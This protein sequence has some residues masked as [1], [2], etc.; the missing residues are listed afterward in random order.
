MAI[1][2]SSGP[3]P[4]KYLFVDGGYLQN[5]LISLGKRMGLAESAPI[6]FEVLSSQYD[7]TI[8]FDAL[9]AKKPN[10]DQADFDKAF[11]AK[12][13]FLNN[14]RRIRNFHVRDGFTR[15]RPRANSGLEQKG[16]DT[17]LAIEALQYAFKG[18]IDVAEIITGDLD[19]YP[20]F[21]ALVQTKTKG[22]LHYELGHTSDELIMAADEAKPMTSHSILPWMDGKFQNEYRS[23]PNANMP[24]EAKVISEIQLSNHAEKCMIWHDEKSGLW[25]AKVG[26]SHPRCATKTKL[27]LIDNIRLW[28]RDNTIPD[29]LF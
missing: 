17:W 22:V 13:T 14:L 23:D 18:T 1:F 29:D 11:D 25:G 9:P 6:D 28:E 3:K 24:E 5:T 12:R 26:D 27:M 20:L 4:I 15:I 16:V 21:E 7:R 10:Q 8:Y 19:L 2:G